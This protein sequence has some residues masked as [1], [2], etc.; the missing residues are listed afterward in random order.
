MR[1]QAVWRRTIIA[2][3]A[4][5]V[6]LYEGVRTKYSVNGNSIKLSSS[7]WGEPV[8]ARGRRRSA[9]LS[10]KLRLLRAPRNY[11]KVYGTYRYQLIET[12]RKAVTAL[13]ATLGTTA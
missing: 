9:W 13:L 10:R 5:V 6:L 11:R 4:L 1:S 12:G 2:L 8:S 7:A 3:L